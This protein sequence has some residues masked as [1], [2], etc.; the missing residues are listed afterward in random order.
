VQASCEWGISVSQCLNNSKTS[1]Y[2]TY[3]GKPRVRH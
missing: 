2:T 3:A 1:G